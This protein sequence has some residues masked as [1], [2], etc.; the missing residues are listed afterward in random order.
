M[1]KI[2]IV[3]D[4]PAFVESTKRLLEA[5]SYE[6][7]SASSGK[8]GF[9]KAKGQKPD[10]IIID[11]MMETWS[12]GL[13]LVSKLQEDE[14]TKHIPRILLTAVGIQSPLEPMSSP[15][16]LGVRTILQ[17]P[18]KPDDLLGAVRSALGEG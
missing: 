5:N 8:E 11:I 10:L 15:E 13:D 9:E 6:V 7:I 2:L 16:A 4:D 18:V 12:A 17:K 1:K 14:E 3:D